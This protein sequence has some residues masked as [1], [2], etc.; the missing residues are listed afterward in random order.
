MDTQIY[1][2]YSNDTNNG[3]Y[4]RLV[5]IYKSVNDA[6]NFVKNNK[7]VFFEQEDEH[8]RYQDY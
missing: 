2:V 7:N 5:K 4:H 6:Q 8:P 3:G 1:N